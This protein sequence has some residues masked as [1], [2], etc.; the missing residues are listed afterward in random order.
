VRRTS[1]PAG[2]R[3]SSLVPPDLRAAELVGALGRAISSRPVTAALIA[4]TGGFVLGGALSFR[5][6]RAALAFAGR[7]LVTELL[8]ELL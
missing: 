8:K 2:K 1:T 5:T 7:Q 3:R 6:G 4:L